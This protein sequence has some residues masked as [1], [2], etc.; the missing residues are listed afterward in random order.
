MRVVL[1][2][3]PANVI[4]KMSSTA[5]TAPASIGIVFVTNT[6]IVPTATTKTAR[7]NRPVRWAIRAINFVSRRPVVQCAHAIQATNSAA[8]KRRA[9]TSTNARTAEI[10]ARRFVTIASDPM[11]APA[12]TILSLVPTRSAASQFSTRDSSCTRPS[13]T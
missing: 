2:S 6:T 7:A 8:T 12:T 13:A 11:N 1:D 5:R 10:H 9:A 3:S 4:R